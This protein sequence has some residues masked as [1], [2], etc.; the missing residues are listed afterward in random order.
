MKNRASFSFLKE[1]R[2]QQTWLVLVIVWACFR[3]VVINDVF[4]SYGVNGWAYFAVD[5]GSA[6]PYAIYSGR[7]L[8]NYLNRDWPA[9]RTNTFLAFI[10]FY[11]PDVYVLIFAKKVPTSLLVGF[12]VSICFFTLLAIWGFHRD[13][14][15]RESDVPSPD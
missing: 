6:I 8:I 14:S 11:I 2:A 15:K 10:F 12:L 1:K 7:C 3:A 5:I 4:G 9:F 13:I